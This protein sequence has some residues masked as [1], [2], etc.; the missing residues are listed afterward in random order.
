[1]GNFLKEIYQE[2]EDWSHSVCASSS[3]LDNAKLFSKDFVLV[4]AP[5]A[6]YKTC[7]CT[8]PQ[9]FVPLAFDEWTSPLLVNL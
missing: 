4:Y 1:M 2:M 9:H 7:Y 6:V 5:T 8:F 3:L